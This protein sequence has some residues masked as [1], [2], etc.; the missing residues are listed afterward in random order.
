MPIITRLI[1]VLMMTIAPLGAQTDSVVAVERT[2]LFPIEPK[3]YL[4]GKFEADTTSDFVLLPSGLT[5]GETAYLRREP[6]AALARMAQ[7]ALDSGVVLTVV[8]AT[9]SYER[10]RAIWEGKF[11]G[12]RLSNGRNLEQE[13]PDPTERCLAILEYSSAPGTSRHHWGTD[14]DLNSTN[15]TYWQT[16]EG[17]VTLGW[18]EHNAN[19]YGF[20]MAYTPDREHGYSYEPW[21]WSYQPLARPLLRY[22]F[23]KLIEDEDLDGF[24]GA[25]YVRQLPWREW[26]IDGVSA[27]LK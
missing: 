7:A 1:P 5:G 10:Q 25:E 6:A 22:Y 3:A 11:E 19:R 12:T 23:H 8:S 9:R 15:L 13:Y 21:H 27:E 18:L 20:Y 16:E 2:R 26:Y 24:F 17:L 14:A 4:L